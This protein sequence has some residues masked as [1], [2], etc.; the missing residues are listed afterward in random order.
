M[1]YGSLAAILGLALTL[2]ACSSPAPQTST[3]TGAA[4]V[5]DALYTSQ[6]P[7][8]QDFQVNLLG[9]RGLVTATLKDGTA[10]IGD[11]AIGQTLGQQV[12]AADK[13]TMLDLSRS[14][15]QAQGTGIFNALGS[16]WPNA[17][18]PYVFDAG[19]NQATRD[20]FLGAKADY[21]NKTVVRF[22]PRTTEANY[23]R[24]I[25]G[26]G[27][28]SY[29]GVIGGAQDLSL[30]TNCGVNPARHEMGHALG[31]NHEQVRTDRDQWVTVNA[32]GASNAID[33]GTGG[34]PNGPYD[35][36]SMMH[37][38]NYFVNGRWDYVPKN[39]FP[40]ELIGNDRYNTFSP[41]DLNAIETLYG[42]KPS[43]SGGAGIGLPAGEWKSFGVTNAGLTGR[44]IRHSG[45]VGY[46]SPVDA[47][48][49]VTTKQD[50]TFRIVG[51][52]DGTPCYSLES[53]NF[54]GSFLRHSGFR[55]RIDANNGS[56]LMRKD[57]TF[58]AQSGLAGTGVSL[59]SRNVPGYYIRHRDGQVWL[60]KNDDSALF[61]QDASW[62]LAA[63]W[64]P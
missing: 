34:T 53:R 57:A 58:C 15:V 30:G 20:A 63:P 50:A 39:G 42:K 38:R 4:T 16:R 64:A 51:A 27:C 12:I 62:A 11:I 41:G 59:V 5:N 40:P 32:D 54:P 1:K 7:K 43:D 61:K 25:T 9:Y 35:F 22:V 8:G 19:A 37:Y 60:D 46:T 3:P 6:H 26:S 29:I 23:L 48:S 47:G 13:Q 45:S 28:Y 36:E 14:A 31:L 18:I 49:T 52:L 56:D 21:D 10:F 44:Y 2:Q 33:Y 24:V 17:V 55:L